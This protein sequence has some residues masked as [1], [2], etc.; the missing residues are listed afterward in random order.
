MKLGPDTVAVA[1]DAE[2]WV[3]D[4]LRRALPSERDPLLTEPQWD[5]FLTCSYAPRALVFGPVRRGKRTV[6]RLV[7]DFQEA[8][9]DRRVLMFFGTDYTRA[10][11]L[12]RSMQ[13]DTV[14]CLDVAAAAIEQL[15]DLF[16]DVND[17]QLIACAHTIITL[18]PRVLAKFSNVFHLPLVIESQPVRI[19]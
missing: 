15:V 6:A 10:R 14:V 7:A 11:Q 16:A 17:V 1:C 9:L 12:V 4:W 13:Y 19:P 2:P 18:D 8:S 3:R 5:V